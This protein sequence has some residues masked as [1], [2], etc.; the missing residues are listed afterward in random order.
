MKDGLMTAHVPAPD[1]ESQSNPLFSLAPRRADQLEMLIRV[2]LE[3][4][5]TLAALSAA[6]A[7]GRDNRHFA[8]QLAT[9]AMRAVLNDDLP[10]PAEVVIGEGVRDDAPMLHIGESLGPQ[11]LDAPVVQIAVDPLEGTNLCARNEQGAITVI[12]AAISGEG[13]LLGGIDGYMEKI[14]LADDLCESLADLRNQNGLFRST[15]KWL[16]DE[17]IENTIRW[18]AKVR[19]KPI[20]DVV[21]M[22]LERPRNQDLIRRLRELNVQVVPIRDG[23]ITAGLL[24]LDGTHDVDIAVGIGAA[25]EG[26][27]TAAM[28]QVYRGYMEARWWFPPDEKG[29]AQRAQLEE[30]GFDVGKVY[31]TSDLA[32]GHVLFALTAVTTN[33][34]VPGVKYET[35]GIAQT[36][37]ISGR[38]RTGT[39]YVSKG[40]H[41]MPPEP[42]TSWPTPDY[43]S[44]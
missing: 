41:R 27:I 31:D 9:E 39:L 33:E 22:V 38:S 24:A 35:G 3:K 37:T 17:P 25:A 10:V 4:A 32:H 21:A 26:V 40:T 13:T 6:H 23:D 19:D 30:R 42:P 16:L 29:A 5:T 18:I 20:T 12:A 34:F 14:V 2:V 36:H 44:D 15:S 43:N 1:D 7:R 28:T 11:I 8:D